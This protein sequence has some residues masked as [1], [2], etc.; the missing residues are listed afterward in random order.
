MTSINN[1]PDELVSNE[2]KKSFD[3][4]QEVMSAVWG[5]WEHK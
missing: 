5:E 3:F 4:A 1:F 2:K